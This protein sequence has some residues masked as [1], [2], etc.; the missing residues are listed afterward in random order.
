MTFG[1]ARYRQI[2]SWFGLKK[3]IGENYF[4]NKLH[5]WILYEFWINE[6]EHWHVNLNTQEYI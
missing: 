2:K 6:E 5:F 4:V 1:I 3:R